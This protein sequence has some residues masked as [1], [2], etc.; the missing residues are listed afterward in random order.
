MKHSNFDNEIEKFEGEWFS[1]NWIDALIIGGVAV[2]FLA[3][4]ILIV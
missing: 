3:L 2:F 4:A 1:F